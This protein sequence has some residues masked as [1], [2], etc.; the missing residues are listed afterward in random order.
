MVDVIILI[1]VAVI[2][3]FAFRGSVKHFKGEG[4][5]CGGGTKGLIK[6]EDKVLEKSKLGEKIIKIEGMH[7]EHCKQSVTSALNKIDGV[8][9][10][11]NLKKGEAAVS[12]DRKIDESQLK[13]V[14]EEAGY[15]VVSIH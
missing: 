3:V 7:C 8:A 14:V 1:I 15:H 4:S 5:C 12:Y 2:I 11:V 10:I 9:A 6:E 13:K